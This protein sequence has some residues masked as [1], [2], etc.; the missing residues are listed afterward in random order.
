MAKNVST[1]LQF[2]LGELLATVAMT[3]LGMIIF[4]CFSTPINGIERLFIVGS[5]TWLSALTIMA[6][7]LALD[8]QT[9]RMVD[10]IVLGWLCV[11]FFLW[12]ASQSGDVFAVFLLLFLVFGLAGVATLI[13]A[14][15]RQS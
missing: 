8:R 7:K 9:W 12:L 13:V 10:R 5:T 6:E 4:D 2:S 1:T 15:Y 11:A 3:F 14:H